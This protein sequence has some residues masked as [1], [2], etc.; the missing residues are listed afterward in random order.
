[1]ERIPTYRLA[2]L[3]VVLALTLIASATYVLSVDVLAFDWSTAA[4]GATDPTT[5]TVVLP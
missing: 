5:P 2:A 4:S 1:M 3:L